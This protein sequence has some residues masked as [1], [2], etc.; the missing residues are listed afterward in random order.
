[1]PLKYDFAT[2][3]DAALGW[4][5]QTSA[6]AA[7]NAALTLSDR[8]RDARDAALEAIQNLAERENIVGYWL[9]GWSS[10]ALIRAFVAVYE[11]T[12]ISNGGKWWWGCSPFLTPAEHVATVYGLDLNFRDQVNADTG[13]SVLAVLESEF[14]VEFADEVAVKLGWTSGCIAPV[15]GFFPTN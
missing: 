15:L 10:P 14:D 2:V 12:L 7:Y 6:R 4:E 13:L 1:M 3:E 9:R 11:D 8:D 5:F